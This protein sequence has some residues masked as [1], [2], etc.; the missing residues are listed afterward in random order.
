METLFPLYNTTKAVQET[1]LYGSWMVNESNWY[2][3]SLNYGKATMK[4]AT[5]SYN[6][7]QQ[8]LDANYPD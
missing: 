3:F 8:S 4:F 2:P 5:K 1:S 7:K 6:S